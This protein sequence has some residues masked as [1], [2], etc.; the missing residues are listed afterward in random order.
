MKPSH[1]KM[2]LPGR[3]TGR[4]IGTGWL[5]V[6]IMLFAAALYLNTLAN[7]F[8]F[9]DK[10]L[11]RENPQLRGDSPG[12]GEIFG[13]NYRSGIGFT[14]EGLYRPLVI[15][16]YVLN[17]NPDNLLPFHAVNVLLHALASGALFLLLCRL[18]GSAPIPLVAGLL[19]AAH[20][21]HTE[22]VAN[23]AGRPELMAALF[24]FAAWWLF[25]RAVDGSRTWVLAGA[26]LF[27]CALLSKETAVV[28]P[29]M[30]LGADIFRRRS[31]YNG[32]IVMQY[33]V[34]AAV[35]IGYGALRLSVLGTSAA[36]QVPDFVDN[37]LAAAPV[38]ERVATALAVFLRYLW[39][40]I[41]PLNLSA[42]YSYNQ[43]PVVES[44]AAPLSV[45]GIAVLAA[46]MVVAVLLGRNRPVFGI[47]AVMFLAPWVLV[48]NLLFPI[49]TIMG[50]RLMYLSSAGFA[51]ALAAPLVQLIRLKRVIGIGAVAMLLGLYGVRTVNRNAEWRNDF[52]LFS[53]DVETAPN[54]VKIRA[55]LG[56]LLRERGDIEAALAAYQAAVDIHPRYIPA[57]RGLARTLYDERRY[58]EAA[59]LYAR[60][61]EE[62]PGNASLRFDHGVALAHA[63]RPE[64][65][66]TAFRSAISLDPSAPL[67]YQEMGTVMARQ[68]RYD[69]ALDWFERALEHS[70]D[71]SV[72]YNN[73]A[74][75]AFFEGEY[76]RA[77]GY[78]EKAA[79]KGIALNP[80]MVGEIIRASEGAEK[81]QRP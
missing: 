50:E 73:L 55:N 53:A 16:S 11:I 14:N 52:T 19:F 30:V 21:I 25:E 65:A 45:L 47:A 56:H 40:H 80:E 78:V 75:T 12:L 64:D 10:S 61:V 23:I 49:G 51:L 69:E 58:E 9:D 57:L 3:N 38:M 74:A 42:D 36:G 70:G 22:A 46:I 35:L 71:A 18:A 6:I 2:S 67:P 28:F 60:A 39:L 48:S 24:I 76:A 33:G 15:L 20:P 26:I 1:N 81:G 37:P 32:R 29:F 79:S 68:G 44:L 54:S 66:E 34:L 62:E 13:S 72:L 77:R 8:A 7:E 4:N 41:F 63:G 5:A 59:S 31:I 27:A 17:G 43:V